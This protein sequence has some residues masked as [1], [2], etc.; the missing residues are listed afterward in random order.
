VR[1]VVIHTGQSY[2][3]SM[4]RIFSRELRIPNP[5]YNLG[6]VAG[7]HGQNTGQ[8]LEASLEC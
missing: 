2:D 8:M 5:D 7:I 1:E 6:I 3:E 4:L